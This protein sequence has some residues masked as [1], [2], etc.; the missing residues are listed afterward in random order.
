[1]IMVF[2]N[3]IVEWCGGAES[4]GAEEITKDVFRYYFGRKHRRPCSLMVG[5]PQ[6]QLED[7]GDAGSSPAGGNT[8][9]KY[10]TQEG[11]VPFTFV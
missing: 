3:L 4:I 10:R 6:S 9:L 7:A 11:E 5:Q 8:D 2:L 1:M